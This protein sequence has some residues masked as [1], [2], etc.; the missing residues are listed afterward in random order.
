M[1]ELLQIDTSPRVLP[2]ALSRAGVRLEI[3]TLAWK[4]VEC[5][6]T[7]YAA[8]TAHSPAL[9][10][11]GSDS[12]VELVSAIVVL[13]QGSTHKR[14]LTEAQAARLA[15]VLLTVLAV[16]VVGA[17]VGSLFLHIRPDTSRSG[18][19]I[20]IASLLL[21]PFLARWKRVEARRIGNAALAADA[22]QSA[23]CAY[24]ALLTLVG[25]AANAAFGIAW[26]DDLAALLAV[27]ILLREANEAFSGHHHRHA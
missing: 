16:V 20:T 26:F 19:A 9:L 11:F 2:G 27:P 24:L 13:S 4:V 1:P 8:Y 12:V 21:M 7:A 17:A 22:V 18:M 10:A 3:V 23:T 15:G 25:L 5:G 6:V 14:R